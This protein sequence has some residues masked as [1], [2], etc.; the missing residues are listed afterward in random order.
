MPR[1]FRYH[2]G[3]LLGAQH[4]FINQLGIARLRMVMVRAEG[5]SQEWAI[6]AGD[7]RLVMMIMALARPLTIGLN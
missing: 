3:G 6:G 1:P 5:W 4:L 2:S 7:G